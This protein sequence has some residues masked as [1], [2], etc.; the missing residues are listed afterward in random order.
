M[1]LI[2]LTL[3]LASVLLKRELATIK[4]GCSTQF[5]GKSGMETLKIPLVFNKIRAESQFVMKNPFVRYQAL[6]PYPVTAKLKDALSNL[7][8]DH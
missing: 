2:C 3:N 1:I 4:H 8:Q 5:I 6:S 7:L